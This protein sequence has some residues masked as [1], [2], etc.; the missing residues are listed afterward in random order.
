MLDFDLAGKNSFRCR[1]LR[2]EEQIPLTLGQIVSEIKDS[3]GC[4]F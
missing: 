3:L 4:P 1:M 2:C